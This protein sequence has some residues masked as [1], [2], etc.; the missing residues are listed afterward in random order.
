M[1]ES[2]RQTQPDSI[3][4]LLALRPDL[5]HPVPRDLAELT[6]Q[7]TATRSVA[8]ALDGLNA[9]QRQVAEAL[10]ALPD[11]TTTAGVADLLGSE[12]DV[13]RPAVDDLRRRALLWGPDDRLHLLRAVREQFGPYPGTLAP[14][15]ARPLPPSRVAALIAECGADVTEV[16]ARLAWSP[17]GAL[18][19]A[20]RTVSAHTA[21]GPVEQLLARGLL[22]PLDPETVILPREVAW[23]VRQG[24]FARDPIGPEPPPVSGRQRKPDLIDRAAAGAAYGVVHDLELVGHALDRR[25][26]RLLRDGG[27]AQRDVTA[28][29]RE[30]G[31]APDY[32]GFLIE[33]G[34]A[35]VFAA[36]SDQVLRPTR[37]FDHW[38][39]RAPVERW[40]EVA[41]AWLQSQR[42]FSRSVQPDSRPL[43]PEADVPYAGVLR[44]LVLELGVQA[45]IGVVPDLDELT[46][47]VAW[48]RPRLA[49][50]PLRLEQGIAWTRQE[51]AWLGLTALDAMSSLTVA[52]LSEGRADD[53]EATADESGWTELEGLFPAPVETVILQADLTAVAGGPLP[54]HLAADLR[55]L[56]DQESRGGG[57]VYRFSD[58]SLRRGLDAGWSP[59][60]IRTW[61]Q[62]HS[63]TE[64][65]Q[66]LSYLISDVA[67]HHGT[68]RVGSAETYVEVDD[69][70]K[71]AAL[72][73]DA[74]AVA[75][76]LRQ[77][78]AGALVAQA[79]PDEVV[80]FLER[81]GHHPALAQDRGRTTDP[82]PRAPTPRRSAPRQPPAADVAAA[83]LA[84]EA[85][86]KALQPTPLR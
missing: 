26:H 75:L 49:R 81:L 18:A 82:P 39:H 55:L 9:W 76:G 47:A 24:R 74:G 58:R 34:A 50:A 4:T 11:P 53:G 41:R 17:T 59:E 66:P 12:L 31:R 84:G 25:P 77:V 68:I 10:A 70:V 7:A 14:P 69:P 27:L 5:G 42:L 6:T 37:E 16:L 2:L 54:P 28:V 32:A 64:V 35:S 21:R 22:Q 80:R 45:G 62:A 78:G 86:D 61:L 13:C 52:L 73:A 46:T 3:V 44:R 83:V 19:G 33:C 40:R 63:S 85:V 67:R 8:R 23:H 30:L 65:P 48:H 57:E 51:A 71:I 60:R 72:L 79:Q 20:D 36:G 29:A 38:L 15:S 56:A 1:T 43:G